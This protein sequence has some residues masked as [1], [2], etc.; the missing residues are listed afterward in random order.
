MWTIALP[1]RI[2]IPRKTKENKV[3]ALNLNVYRNTHPHTLNQA[4]VIF[5]DLVL[6]LVVNAGVP[7]LKLCT[8]EYHLYVGSARECDVN[9]VCSI[10]DKFFSDTLVH[11]GVLEDDNYKFLAETRFKFGGIDRAN[12]RVEAVIRSPDHIPLVHPEPVQGSH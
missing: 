7:K 4:K 6:P 8:L 9:N 10:V 5:N 1:L 11:A 12:P 3:F 2:E